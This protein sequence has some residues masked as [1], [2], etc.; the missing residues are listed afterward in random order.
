M[1]W[2]TKD[3]Q[4][5]YENNEPALTYTKA[6]KAGNWWHY[7]KWQVVII[8]I[9]LVVIAAS[10]RIRSSAPSPTTRSAMWG[11]RSFPPTPP[12]R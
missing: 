2:V 11:C 10:S 7:H 4:E 5:T 3:S 12:K 6:E 9:L 8:I 1:A